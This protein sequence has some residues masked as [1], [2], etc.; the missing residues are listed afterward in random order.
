M[1]FFCKLQKLYGI[2]TIVAVL[3]SHAVAIIMIKLSF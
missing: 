2:N 1:V 3:L